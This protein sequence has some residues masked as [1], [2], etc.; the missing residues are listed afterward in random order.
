MG[1]PAFV[2]GIPYKILAPKNPYPGK[3]PEVDFQAVCDFH[4]KEI[5]KLEENIKK[6]A[7]DVDLKSELYKMLNESKSLCSVLEYRVLP[8]CATKEGMNVFSKL[9]DEC[10][11]NKTEILK[12]TF[13]RMMKLDNA[14]SGKDIFRSCK[15][16]AAKGLLKQFKEMQGLISGLCPESQSGSSRKRR[17]SYGGGFYN[18]NTLWFQYLLCQEQ[19][20]TCYFFT[21]GWNQGDY[22]QYY[23]YQNA[24][25][26]DVT[27]PDDATPDVATDDDDFLALALL[28]GIG[29]P[30][31]YPNKGY[32]AH[33]SPAGYP[34]YPSPA[35]P[36][37]RRRRET[38]D[39]EA[40]EDE[41]ETE[42]EEA[43]DTDLV[44]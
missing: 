24:L 38:K 32:P 19:K 18:P 43:I 23:L 25:D 4:S 8:E 11:E 41:E 12:S 29:T 34:A 26:A 14:P 22:G 16:I 44:P 39:E 20:I 30:K 40:I 3:S 15:D 28:S 27:T 21:Q 7:Q 9:D 33:P 1:I 36:S 17:S 31:Y 37:F 5:D 10:A 42:D 13:L 35:Y 6:L 2:M